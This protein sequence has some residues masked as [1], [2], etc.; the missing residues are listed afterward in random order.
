MIKVVKHGDAKAGVR[1]GTK[2]G[3]IECAIKVV[4]QA[5]AIC[6]VAKEYGGRLRNS[7]MWKSVDKEGGLNNSGG[8]K[9]QALETKAGD[10]DVLVG[11]NVE[12]STY[13]EFG[14]RNIPP[15][16][17]LR[18]AIAIHGFGA[19]AQQ[20]MKKRAEEVM[21]GKLEEGQDRVKFF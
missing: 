13:Q 19:D 4:S 18:P 10:M 8:E 11:S 6:P 21:K 7:I 3:M 17:F 12:Y 5:K 9:A 2:A 20:T 15:Q 16:P 1:E 14:T